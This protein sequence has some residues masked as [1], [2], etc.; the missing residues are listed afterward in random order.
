M[1]YQDE[2]SPAMELVNG[3]DHKIGDITE[4]IIFGDL[5]VSILNLLYDFHKRDVIWVDPSGLICP[6]KA[7]RG[8]SWHFF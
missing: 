1:F 7:W 6:R 4:Q 3:C 2:D 8:I 5:C